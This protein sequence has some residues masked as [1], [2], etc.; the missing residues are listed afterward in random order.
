M[1]SMEH[2]PHTAERDPHTTSRA[3]TDLGSDGPQQRLNLAPGKI[4]RGRLRKDPTEGAA[5]A[6]VHVT[7]IAKIDIATR[8]AN[9]RAADHGLTLV[10]RRP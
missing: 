8:W 2:R 6:A 5:V 7:M 3:F 9:A 1:L 4:D 10:R